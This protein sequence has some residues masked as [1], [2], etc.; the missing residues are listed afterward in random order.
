MGKTRDSA[1]ARV[2][3]KFKNVLFLIYMAVFVTVF[4]LKPASMRPSARAVIV[5]PGDDI[6]AIVAGHPAGT[7]F[8]LTLG[9]YRLQSIRPRDE[10]SFTGEPGAILSG[11]EVLSN[12][13]QE[14]RYWVAAI[15]V[16]RQSSYRG[17]CDQDHTACMFPQDLYVDDVPLRRVGSLSAVA[18]GKWYLDYTDG[19]AFLGENPAG[20]KV[21]ISLTSHGFYGSAENVTIRGLTIEKYADT[22]GDGAIEGGSE[23][24]APSQGWVIK[25]NVIKLNHGMGIRLGNQMQVINNKVVDNGQMGLGGSGDRILVAGNEIAYNNYAGYD[26]GWEAGGTK[27]TFTK[28]LVVRDNFVHNND[29]PGLWTDIE[30]YNTLYENNRTTEN[31]EAGILHEISYHAV[32]RDNTIQN[33]GFSAS[34]KTAPWY[35]GGIVVTAS[36]DVEIYGNTVTDCMNGVIGL[37]P[38]RKRQAGGKYFLR[39]LDVHNNVITQRSGIA[40]GILESAS[41]DNSVFTSWNNRFADNTF[42]LDNQGG[43]CFAWMN[44]EHTLAAWQGA[45]PSR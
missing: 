2:S 9:V 32:I 34:G 44:A 24:H 25:D 21:E 45:R 18:A 23:G 15:T 16:H 10:D 29:G 8:D 6:E 26:Y 19:K 31:K 38:N 40:A 14:G 27:F 35:G 28:D 7:S 42:H 3:H 37:Q 12:F 17:E 39:N 20:H 30:N 4:T 36:E 43:K 22:A 11:A 1:S 33:D 5:R 13:T 41:F